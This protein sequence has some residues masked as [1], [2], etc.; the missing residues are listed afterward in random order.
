MLVLGRSFSYAPPA[1][2]SKEFLL[3]PSGWLKWGVSLP[4]LQLV[5]MRSFSY[6]PDASFS[7]EFLLH[8]LC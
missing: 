2:F 8:S 3:H 7:E 4:L 6:T 1:R 5:E